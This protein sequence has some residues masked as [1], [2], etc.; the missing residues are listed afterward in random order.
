MY[1]LVV[2]VTFSDKSS[3]VAFSVSLS[4]G[5]VSAWVVI[6]WLDVIDSDLFV[7]VL[8]LVFLLFSA[9]LKRS[10][11]LFCRSGSL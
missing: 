9:E 4:L 3:S 1:R 5:M 8:S 7:T 2:G 10:T 6:C 11:F